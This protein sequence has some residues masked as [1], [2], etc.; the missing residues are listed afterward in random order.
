MELLLGLVLSS[1]I[2][3]V[4]A[5]IYNAQTLFFNKELS[6]FDLNSDARII[7]ASFKR[8][9]AKGVSVLT[10]NATTLMINTIEN[11]VVMNVAWQAYPD[12]GR[13][14]LYAPAGGLG[15]LLTDKLMNQ[16]SYFS[17]SVAPSGIELVGVDFE[18]GDKYGQK[19]KR[20]AVYRLILSGDEI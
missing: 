7:L 17:N 3:G 20:H 15:Y 8:Y 11:N 10:C 16:S 18:L 14:Y 5:G 1:I 13:M 2:F 4:I 6:G 12:D 19:V 9:T